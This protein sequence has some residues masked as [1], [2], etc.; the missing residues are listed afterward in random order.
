MAKR[1]KTN[2]LPITRNLTLIYHGTIIFVQS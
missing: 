1:E 2:P